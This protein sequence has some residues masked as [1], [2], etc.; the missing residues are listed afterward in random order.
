MAAALAWTAA[1]GASGQAVFVALYVLACVAFLPGSILTLGAGAAF[2]LWKGFLLVSAG[3]T[4]GACAAFL[5]GRH[6]LRERI[7]RRM[8]KV[9]AFAAI[10]AAVGHEGWKVV[11]LTRLSPVLPFNLLNY[12]YGLTTVRLR[13]YALASWIGMMPGTFLYVYLG[14]AAGEI[15]RAGSHAHTRAEW[16]LY[17]TG[18]IATA[19]AAW[20]VGRTARRALSAKKDSHAAV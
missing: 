7:S 17:A 2:G 5:I 6:L 11:I 15:A 10:A 19:A 16:A 3:S 20:L 8:E 9:P 12:G 14:A 18:L 1:T 13:E 4:L